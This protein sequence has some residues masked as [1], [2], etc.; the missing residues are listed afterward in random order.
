MSPFEV[1]C[2]GRGTDETC[3]VYLVREVLYDPDPNDDDAFSS[4]PYDDDH[5]FN[6]HSYDD[7]SPADTPTAASPP[8]RPPMRSWASDPFM[9]HQ[10]P[11]YGR[12]LDRKSVV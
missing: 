9:P 3:S 2:G 6:S 8:S 10:P 7:Y 5:S 1:A 11:V 12:N 4:F